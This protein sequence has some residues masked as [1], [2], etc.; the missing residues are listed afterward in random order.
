V[1]E[2]SSL[3]RTASGTEEASHLLDLLN[4]VQTEALTPGV[5]FRIAE[6]AR[7]SL[8]AN[9]LAAQL[10][11][12]SAASDT[13][14]LFAPK[15]LIAALSLLPERRDSIIAVLDTRYA[16]SPYALAFHGEASIAYAAA[17]DS[18]AHE[19]GMQVG[20]TSAAPVGARVDLPLPGPRGPKFP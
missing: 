7:D 18:L 17:E 3:L 14:S 5:R 6:L 8:L 1:A 13:G 11:L 20:R 4:R 10:F 19:L 12:E 16:A 2:L 9:A 15:A